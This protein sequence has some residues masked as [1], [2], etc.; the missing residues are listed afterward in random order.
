MSESGACRP[1]DAAGAAR[2]RQRPPAAPMLLDGHDWLDGETRPRCRVGSICPD[3]ENSPPC[4]G[5]E[6]FMKRPLP[7]EN[8]PRQRFAYFAHLV[9][10]RSWA[11]S[12]TKCKK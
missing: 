1:L 4:G 6:K 9:A 10:R 7:P 12:M 11:V 2:K 3:A 8:D 5:A